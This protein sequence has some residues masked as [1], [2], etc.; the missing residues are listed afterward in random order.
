MTRRPKHTET[1]YDSFN[2]RNIPVKEVARTFVVND[3]YRRLLKNSSIVLM[4]PRGSGKTT[5][6]KMLT[7]EALHSWQSAEAKETLRTIPFCA[8]YIPTD[9]HWKRQLAHTER[10]LQTFPKFAE[11]VS[12]AA[13]TLNV[14]KALLHAFSERMQYESINERTEEVG[15][16]AALTECWLLDSRMPDFKSLRSAIDHRVSELSTRAKVLEDR[17][18]SNDAEPALGQ[19]FYLDY[20]H[21]IVAACSAFDE[22]VSVRR[23]LRWALCFDE[24][25]LAPGWL[26]DRLFRELR[27]SDERVL[28]R[29]STSPVPAIAA[30][31]EAQP[32]QD[33]QNVFLWPRGHKNPRD[34]PERLAQ[35]TLARRLRQPVEPAQVFG[36]SPMYD[37][38]D[39]AANVRYERGSV[40]YKTIREVAQWDQGVRHTLTNHDISPEDPTTSD[41]KKK[42]QVLRKMKPLVYHRLLLRKSGGARSRKL[43]PAYFGAGAIYDI[44]DANPRWL[45]GIIDDL[46]EAS[47]LSAE[48]KPQFSKKVQIRVL[49]Q[50]S[51]QFL[52]LLKALPDAEVQLQGGSRHLF[53]ILKTIGKYFFERLVVDKFTLDPVGSFYVD[54]KTDRALWNLLR[55]AAY[56]GAIVNVDPETVAVTGDLTN[57][58]FRLSYMLAPAFRLPLRLYEQVP[59]SSCLQRDSLFRRARKHG[60]KKTHSRGQQQF[61]FDL[62][63]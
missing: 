24:L 32:R 35:A 38:G 3:D 62:A 41:P 42:D 17:L 57:K 51:K 11:R 9:V 60:V 14:L 15:L 21:A 58:R 29:L 23:P 27:S 44:S 31:I 34:F 19:Q 63:R 48:K 25:E 61:W 50:A 8:V 40:A 43:L 45:I 30:D 5:L 10:S 6:L 16:C 33:Y 53:D 28:F 47:P 7:L 37:N 18:S 59:L 54:R 4:G 22:F 1:L 56:Q 13:V 12:E 49:T 36:A 52:S 46:L 39:D 26:Q 2:A 20:Y 55:L